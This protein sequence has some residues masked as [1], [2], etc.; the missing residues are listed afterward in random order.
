MRARIGRRVPLQAALQARPGDAT[1]EAFGLFQDAGYQRP[2]DAH[3]VVVTRRRMPWGM[4]VVYDVDAADKGHA[5]IHRHEL[6]VQAPQPVAPQGQR[7]GLGAEYQHFDV[8]RI[9]ERPRLLE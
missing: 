8:G 4:H 3:R 6:A 2:F 5:R 9:E 7:R 1:P